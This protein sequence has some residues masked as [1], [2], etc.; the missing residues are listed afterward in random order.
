VLPFFDDGSL[1]ELEEW[2]IIS[3]PLTAFTSVGDESILNIKY[4]DITIVKI[5]ARTFVVIQKL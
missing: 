3:S 5:T 1:I 2:V 4:T